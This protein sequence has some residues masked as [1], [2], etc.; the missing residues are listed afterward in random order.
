VDERRAFGQLEGKVDMLEI[1]VR[2]MKGDLK[3]VREILSE[4]KGGW[5]TMILLGS[6]IAT[7]SSVVTWAITTFWKK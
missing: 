6:M 4:A 1:D 7:L 2:E 3:A 5:R